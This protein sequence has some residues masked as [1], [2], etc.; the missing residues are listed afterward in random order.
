MKVIDFPMTGVLDCVA[1]L[2]GLADAIENGDHGEVRNIAWVMDA[3]GQNVMG[4][5]GKAS[6]PDAL[7]CLML[8]LGKHGLLEQMRRT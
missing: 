8:E 6:S 1:G 2:R 7:F 3:D 5:L 4:L